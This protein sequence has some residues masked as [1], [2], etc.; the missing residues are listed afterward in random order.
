LGALASTAAV[1]L[2][3][4][5]VP[6]LDPPSIAWIAANAFVLVAVAVLAAWIPARRASSVDP[7]VALKAM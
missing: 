1:R 6:A 4:R 2:I 5:F 7:L 3:A